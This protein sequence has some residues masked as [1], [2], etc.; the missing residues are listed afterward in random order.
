MLLVI[1]ILVIF[2]EIIIIPLMFMEFILR[3]FGKS[4]DDKK[5]KT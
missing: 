4:F 2:P 5:P 1:G 3:L